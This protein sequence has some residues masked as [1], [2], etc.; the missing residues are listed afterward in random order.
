M[1]D[2]RDTVRDSETTVFSSLLGIFY[3]L[4]KKTTKGTHG[5]NM[6]YS[7]L[8]VGS[9]G[10]RCVFFMETRGARGG[11]AAR[12]ARDLRAGRGG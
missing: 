2:V 5:L 9:R 6:K 12:S 10:G 4:A 11:G 7:V 8:G 1:G 3:S